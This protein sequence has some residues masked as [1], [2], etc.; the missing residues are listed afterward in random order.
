MSGADGRRQ[1][2]M[3]QIPFIQGGGTGSHDE[4]DDELVDSLER[5]LGSGCEVRCPRLP[6]EDA[7]STRT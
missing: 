5:E 6:D 7:P 1:P 3:R 4:W 2:E